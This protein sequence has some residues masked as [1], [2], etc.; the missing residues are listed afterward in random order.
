[1]GLVRLGLLVVTLAG[2]VGLALFNPTVD[3]YLVFIEYELSKAIDRMDQTMPTQEQQFIRQVFR[4][5]SKKLLES[6]VRPH[7]GR[8]N[9]GLFSLYET[10]VTDVKVVVLGIGG[11]FLPLSGVDEAIRKIGRM[12]F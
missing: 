11:Q 5:Q 9:W 7:T 10:N 8:H 12:A 2:A 6:I 4:S 1:M 3:D